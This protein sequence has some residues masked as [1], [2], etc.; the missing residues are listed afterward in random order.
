MQP[1]PQLRTEFLPYVIG[2]M[3]TGFMLLGCGMIPLFDPQE[4]QHAESARELLQNLPSL[5]PSWNGTASAATP[6]VSIW[7]QAM[8]FALFGE[9]ELVARL[10]AALATGATAGLI[11][12]TGFSLLQPATAAFTG[13]AFGLCLQTQFCGRAATA[14]APALFFA[15]AALHLAA[16]FAQSKG[17]RHAL[18]L[19]ILSLSACFLT[20]GIRALATA[21]PIALLALSIVARTVRLRLIA[22]AGASLIPALAWTIYASTQTNAPWAELLTAQSPFHFSVVSMTDYLRALPF[23]AA[24]LLAGV[25][26][27]AHLLPDGFRMLRTA[28]ATRDI[29]RFFA[30][31]V[32]VPLALFTLAPEKHP[33]QVLPSLPGLLLLAGLGAET[34][35]MSTSRWFTLIKFTAVTLVLILFLA[36]IGIRRVSATYNLVPH[37]RE[38]ARTGSAAAIC[39]KYQEPS[40]I[41]E[42]RKTTSAYPSRIDP[43]EIVA[44]LKG[45]GVRFV[46]CTEEATNEAGLTAPS[47]VADGISLRDGTRVR[48]NVLTAADLPR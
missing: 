12:Q 5:I 3:V 1:T 33:A 40:L 7:L 8:V 14:D 39:G 4:A 46:I 15:T 29:A 30:L 16:R 36:P 20:I 22:A 6:P 24:V 26:P 35:G 28:V 10:P 44:W 43:E 18:P 47:K 34:R 31:S 37:L 42:I 9:S 17:T 23:H 41:W 19:L 45:S 25:L 48:L 32:M 27:F 2:A 38:I 11:V 13:L 21:I